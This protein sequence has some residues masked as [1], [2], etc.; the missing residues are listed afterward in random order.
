M[1]SIIRESFHVCS[2]F[3]HSMTMLKQHRDQGKEYCGSHGS[4][5]VAIWPDWMVTCKLGNN[6]WSRMWKC[7]MKK[8]LSPLAVT[9]PRRLFSKDQLFQ[10][11]CYWYT[12]WTS[13]STEKHLYMYGLLGKDL[14][15][16]GRWHLDQLST[17]MVVIR[18]SNKL[19]PLQTGKSLT[20]CFNFTITKKKKKNT[21]LL[22]QSPVWND[23][24]GLASDRDPFGRT[25]LSGSVNGE[26]GNVPHF[27]QPCRN[28]W[29][30][31]HTFPA[32]LLDCLSIS[33]DTYVLQCTN[34]ELSFY[35]GWPF[36][37]GIWDKRIVTYLAFLHRQVRRGSSWWRFPR[38][39]Q[40]LSD[41]PEGCQ[42][43]EAAPT[44]LPGPQLP[45]YLCTHAERD[46]DCGNLYGST[47]YADIP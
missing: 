1:L 35:R 44:P 25:Q 27:W 5:W 31:K 32:Y 2:T 22:L 14:C 17:P 42:H 43:S 3:C 33:A 16:P 39:F 23:K 30:Q 37:S 40:L 36:L 20:F 41:H 13:Y 45:L 28:C 24:V 12:K 38:T 47:Q 10:C 11:S 34:N 7:H 18:Y 21:L 19:Q 26:V 29:I 8:M 9:R 4:H 6:I 15:G 46:I